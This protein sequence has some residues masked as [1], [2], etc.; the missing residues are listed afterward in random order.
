LQFTSQRTSK[1]QE[2]P[3]A[4]KREHPALQ[5]MKF[6]DFFLFLWVIFALLDPDPDSESGSTDLIESVPDLDPKH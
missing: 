6:L 1:L 3:S 2:K 4:L 5:N